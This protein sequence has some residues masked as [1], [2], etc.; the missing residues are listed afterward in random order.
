MQF[1]RLPVGHTQH[2]TIQS[3]PALLTRI[4]FIT[5]VKHVILL[6]NQNDGTNFDTCNG[7]HAWLSY[8]CMCVVVLV[9]WWQLFI[10]G[11][12][13]IT[14]CWHSLIS[15]S[16][17]STCDI[18]WLI[19]QEVC[20]STRRRTSY[21]ALAST[22]NVDCMAMTITWIDLFWILLLDTR[23]GSVLILQVFLRNVAASWEWLKCHRRAQLI[24]VNQ[25]VM[26]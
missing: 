9:I 17:S 20:L 24:W 7:N 16:T 18:I 6:V 22:P 23:G 12:D 11:H 2:N 4:T 15:I 13:I 21:S 1:A 14:S 19:Y 25:F 3:W 5:S 8:S 26:S 10:Y